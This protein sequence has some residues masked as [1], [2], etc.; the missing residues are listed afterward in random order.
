[1]NLEHLLVSAYN[2]KIAETPFEI[3]HAQA[4]PAA[5]PPASFHADM[6]TI[7]NL[8]RRHFGGVASWRS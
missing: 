6:A 8:M 7:D 5:G 1:M 4:L 2:L 3:S